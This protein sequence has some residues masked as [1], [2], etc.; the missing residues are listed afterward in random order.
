MT[1]VAAHGLQRIAD[2]LHR[3]VFIDDAELMGRIDDP[4]QELG[5][6]FVADKYPLRQGK[7]FSYNQELVFVGK[8]EQRVVEQY[9]CRLVFLQ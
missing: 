8:V 2:V 6:E 9:R 4:S 1:T 5:R 7:T 3:T